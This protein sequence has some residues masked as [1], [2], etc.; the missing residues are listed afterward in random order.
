M[1]I[2]NLKP[3]DYDADVEQ[4]FIVTLSLMFVDS[5][6]SWLELCVQGSVPSL[7]QKAETEPDCG[8]QR[9]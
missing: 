7:L 8:V 5:P 1:L 9:I 2:L 4:D 6:V 3:L